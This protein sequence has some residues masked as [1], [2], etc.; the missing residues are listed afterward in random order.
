MLNKH[1][2][3]TKP[4]QKTTEVSATPEWLF[5]LSICR[6]FRIIIL[7]LS[8]AARLSSRPSIYYF[9]GRTMNS[10]KLKSICRYLFT[11]YGITEEFSSD[12]GLQ[13][14]AQFFQQFLQDWG[15]AHCL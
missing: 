13:F 11:S 6:L 1:K 14:T 12:G 7:L 10:I 8:I 4:V 9:K 15:I 3:C 5:Q 2:N